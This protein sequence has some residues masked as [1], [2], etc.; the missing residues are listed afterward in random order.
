MEGGS[1]IEGGPADLAIID[2]DFEF[3]LKKEDLHSKSKNSPFIGK[4]L[5]GRNILTMIG[6]SIVWERD[7]E[8][9]SGG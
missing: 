4:S 1:I 5:Q 8:Y 2:P 3:I 6:G 9:F 7:A